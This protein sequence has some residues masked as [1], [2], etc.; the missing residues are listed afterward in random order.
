MGEMKRMLTMAAAA[1]VLCTTLC[2]GLS[3]G[4]SAAD[5]QAPAPMKLR[6]MQGFSYEGKAV[7][8]DIGVSGEYKVQV[9]GP[10]TAKLSESLGALGAANAATFD[11]EEQTGF[12]ESKETSF[13]VFYQGSNDL[14]GLTGWMAYVKMPVNK[15]AAIPNLDAANHPGNREGEYYSRLFIGQYAIKDE[16]MAWPNLGSADV[17]ILD[18][19]GTEWQTLKASEGFVDLPNGFEGYIKV[20]LSELGNTAGTDGGGA[21]MTGRFES[22]TFKYRSMGGE[23]C[24]PAVVNAIYGITEDSDSVTALLGS[25]ETPRFLTNGKTVDKVDDTLLDAAMKGRVLQSFNAYA[26]GA[27][28]MESGGLKSYYLK[29]LDATIAPQVGGIE[30]SPSLKLDGPTQGGFRDSGP[31]YEIYFPKHTQAK[32][33]KGIMFYVKCAAPHKEDTERSRLQM[34][35]YSEGDGGVKYTKLGDGK[36]VKI[37]EKGAKK[38]ATAPSADGNILVLPA[39]FEGYILY[40]LKDM[41]VAPITEDLENRSLISAHFAFHAVGGDAGACYLD[42]MYAVTDMGQKD[43]LMSLNG[44]DVYNLA[45]GAPATREDLLEKG[46][47]IGE[48]FDDIPEATLDKTVHEVGEADLTDTSVK[49]SWDAVDGAAAYRVDVFRTEAAS[50]GISIKYVCAASQKTTDTSLTVSGLS[51]SMRYYVVVSVLDAFDGVTDIFGYQRFMTADSADPIPA[52]DPDS[53]GSGGG[54][55]SDGGDPIPPTGVPAAAGAVTLAALAAAAVIL[56]RKKQ[57]R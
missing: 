39:N 23:V 40:D 4:A 45:T 56:L 53:S 7:G 16:A 17:R 41:T 49:L 35:L 29:D 32:G 44:C 51:A 21:A 25:E 1:A 13:E 37:L 55:P 28:L 11:S 9:N 33:V 22:T 34:T 26:K 3:L 6:L 30:K 8:D 46:P 15:S 18:K 5:E 20:K 52:P 31:F 50:D 10:A 38:W 2:G 47:E 27:D 48:V 42:A 54:T 36:T 24:G 14:T 57:D 43:I 12:S 19:N